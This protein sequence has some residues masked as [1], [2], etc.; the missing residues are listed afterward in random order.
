MPAHYN[1]NKY[2]CS[3]GMPFPN[4]RLFRG[5]LVRNKTHFRPENDT[6]EVEVDD[7]DVE[8]MGVDDNDS[9]MNEAEDF[10]SDSDID[11]KFTKKKKKCY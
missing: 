8:M 11:C 5:H 6:M 3:C 1:L 9:E 2:T 4:L 10:D 7:H